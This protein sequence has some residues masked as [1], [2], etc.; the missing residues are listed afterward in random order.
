MLELL[1]TWLLASSSS[2][3]NHEKT[4]VAVV[5]APDQPHEMTPNEQKLPRDLNPTFSSILLELA[6]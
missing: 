2:F 1:W 4:S 5:R 3:T 6:V